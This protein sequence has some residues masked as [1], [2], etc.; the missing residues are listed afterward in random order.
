MYLEH[1]EEPDYDPL[2]L[3]DLSK[4]FL[5]RITDFIAKKGS[6]FRL[7]DYDNLRTLWGLS[8]E[9]PVFPYELDDK[10]KERFHFFIK[11]RAHEF[12]SKVQYR[13]KLYWWALG[14]G[15]L[16]AFSMIVALG[17]LAGF[18]Q[19]FMDFWH[20]STRASVSIITILAFI[21]IGA[22]MYTAF[23]AIWGDK[24]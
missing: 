9:H 18:T 2:S 1:K 11:Q 3:V 17:M 21:G 6:D 14:T 23:Y 4:V 19:T 20:I 24:Y 10:A 13:L 7:Q 5:L 8:G 22:V 12:D 16:L 15:L